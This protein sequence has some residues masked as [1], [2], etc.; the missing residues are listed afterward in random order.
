[1]KLYVA[2][3]SGNAHKA[4]LFLSILGVEYEAVDVAYLSLQGPEFRVKNPRGQ[5]P[6]LEV[7]GRHIWDSQA[8]LVYLARRYGGED[9]LPTDPDGMAEVMQWL[10]LSENELLLGIAQARIGTTFAAGNEDVILVPLDRAKRYAARGLRVMVERLA[11]HDWLALDRPTIAEM[12]CFTYAAL[13]HEAGI[14]IAPYGAVARWLE[15]VRSLP[16]FVAMPGME[17]V[18]A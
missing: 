3:R 5:I 17:A 9:W 18:P 7:D 1:M 2:E 10:A 14:D 4:R 8:I 6:V 13:T 11:A 15:R 16:G 12:A